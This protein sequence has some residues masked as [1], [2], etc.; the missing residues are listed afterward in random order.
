VFRA[1]SIYSAEVRVN[2]I[3]I[4]NRDSFL[5]FVSSV[6]LTFQQEQKCAISIDLLDN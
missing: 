2:V 6:K 3:I 5:K 4:H 1:N